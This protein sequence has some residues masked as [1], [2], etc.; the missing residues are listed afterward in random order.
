MPIYPPASNAS[1]VRQAFLDWLSGPPTHGDVPTLGQLGRQVLGAAAEVVVPDPTSDPT[2]GMLT[3]LGMANV[4]RLTRPMKEALRNYANFASET[5]LYL[6]EG[7]AGLKKLKPVFKGGLKQT[8]TVAGMKKV[9]KDLDKVLRK[10]TLDTNMTLYRGSPHLPKLKSGD[11]FVDRG[12]VSTSRDPLTAYQFGKTPYTSN[13]PGMVIAAKK[14]QSGYNLKGEEREVIL[15]R[16]LKFRVTDK[17][18]RV[19]DELWPVV[20]PQLGGKLTPLGMG[21]INPIKLAKKP[22]YHFTSS[23]AVK[24]LGKDRPFFMTSAKSLGEEKNMGVLKVKPSVS[25]V[26]SLKDLNRV[27][28]KLREKTGFDTYLELE[29]RYPNYI[30]SEEAP[31]D[32]LKLPEVRRA[33]E[34]EGFDAVKYLEPGEEKMHESLVVW[35]PKRVKITG[36]EA[37]KKALTPLG[38][39]K[40][41]LNLKTPSPLVSWIEPGRKGAIGLIPGETHAQVALKL[42]GKLAPKISRSEVLRRRNLG[43]P[44]I[45]KATD[46]MVNEAYDKLRDKGWIRRLRSMY[47]VGKLDNKTLDAIEEDILAQPSTRRNYI[48][49]KEYGRGSEIHDFGLNELLE[50]GSLRNL[51]RRRE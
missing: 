21:R 35:N 15:P 26:A 16:N 25:K 1:R 11:I 27:V 24:V 50:A 40:M 34:A 19:H 43:K 46:E 22:W 38:F 28:G 30:S 9:T 45:N 36:R 33:M 18:K 20:E 47:S 23:K 44:I 10:S 31:A 39:T 14:G 2:L 12:F 37:Y 49:E 7:S 51:V 29:N 5:N 4:K 41:R 3:P 32:A 17:V 6:R 48:V 13:S 42:L 8:T